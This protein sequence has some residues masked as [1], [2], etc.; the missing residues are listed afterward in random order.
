MII[1]T[2]Q[3]LHI[4]VLNL[5]L[6]SFVPWNWNVTDEKIC[7]SKGTTGGNLVSAMVT[8]TNAACPGDIDCA[9][10]MSLPRMDF[11]L[12][13]K[14]EEKETAGEAEMWRMELPWRPLAC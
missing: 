3:K 2:L 4:A 12:E 10:F 8:H 14:E 13:V 9:P 6:L 5:L 7:R 1:L 11:L